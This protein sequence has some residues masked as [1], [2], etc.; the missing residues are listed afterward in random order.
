MQ[1]WL[2]EE[3]LRERNELNLDGQLCFLDDDNKIKPEY[4]VSG[5]SIENEV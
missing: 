5:G 1:S 2:L 4:I 3:L